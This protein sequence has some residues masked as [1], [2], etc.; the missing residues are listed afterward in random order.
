MSVADSGKAG[1]AS[2]RRIGALDG[3]R[4]IAILLVFVNHA[5]KVRLAWAGVDLFFVLSGFLITGILLG[6]KH[7]RPKAYY[8]RFYGRRARRILP[9]YLLLLLAITPVF[10][11]VGWLRFGYMYAFLM[12]FVTA[13]AIPHLSSLDVLWSLAVEE[14]FYLVWPVLVLLLSERALAWAVGLL[15]VAAPLLRYVCSPEFSNYAPVYM[16]TPFRMD[17]LAAGAGLA[18]VWRKR[19]E[20][21]TRFGGFGPLLSVAALGLLAVF[22]RRQGFSITANTPFANIWIYEMTLLASTGVVLWALSGRA[23]Q[24]LEWVPMRTLGR[25]SYSFY[26]IHTT[27]LIVLQRY[28]AGRWLVAGLTFGLSLA[29]SALSWRYFEQP[30]LYG[31]KQEQAEARVEERAVHQRD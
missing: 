11:G 27:V 9:P 2:E 29:Y 12:N 25:I 22:S 14:Q 31:G 15:M 18:L 26:L 21:I 16:L 3:V 20:W 6:V 24:V 7:L 10:F 28:I 30:M 13:F 17:L 1:H 5:L 23:V 4:G 8:G 19:R